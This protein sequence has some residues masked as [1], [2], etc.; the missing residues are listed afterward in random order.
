M[1]NVLEIFYKLCALPSDINEHLPLL[2]GS[3]Q[4]SHFKDM[5]LDPKILPLLH[6]WVRKRERTFSPKQ[7]SWPEIAYRLERHGLAYKT[8]A[9]GFLLE[10][11]TGPSKQSDWQNMADI[12]GEAFFDLWY[13]DSPDKCRHFPHWRCQVLWTYATLPST[14]GD[15]LWRNFKRRHGLSDR[16]FRNILLDLQEK[17]QKR[18][19]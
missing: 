6:S 17:A 2:H 1:S 4:M 16:K 11:A 14:N 10:H 3:S 18:G 19:L 8:E 7:R 15:E 5:K 12:V 13:E 9:I